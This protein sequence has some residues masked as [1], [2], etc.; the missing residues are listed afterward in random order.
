M[1]RHGPGIVLTRFRNKPIFDTE[2]FSMILARSQTNSDI[3]S[4]N[5]ESNVHEGNELSRVKFLCF[6]VQGQ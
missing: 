1:F 2:V 3:F 6:H 5:S 4:Q